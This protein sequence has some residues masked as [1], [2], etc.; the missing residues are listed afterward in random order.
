MATFQE[1]QAADFVRALNESGKS[2]VIDGTE[3]KVFLRQATPEE[4]SGGWFDAEGLQQEAMYLFINKDHFAVKPKP[5]QQMVVDGD[6]YTVVRADS[7][8][9]ALKILL[10][11]YLS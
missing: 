5:R 9:V 10:S 1:H 2:V 6:K 7:F 3:A 4:F 8:G 11:R